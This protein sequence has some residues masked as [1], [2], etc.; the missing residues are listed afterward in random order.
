MKIHAALD[1]LMPPPSVIEPVGGSMLP[2]RRLK[3]DTRIGD[4]ATE[5]DFRRLCGLALG[6]WL[7]GGSKATTLEARLDSGW[8]PPGKRLPPPLAHEAYVLEIGTRLRLTASAYAGLAMGLQTLKQI[9]ESGSDAGSLPRCRIVDWPRL[10]MRGMHVDMARE[11]EYRPAHLKR[12]VE[13]AAYFRMNTLHLYLENKFV[14]SSA[15]EVAPP[16]V[17]TPAQAR[18]L[19]EYA[20]LFGVTVLPQIPTLGHMEHLLNGKYA[21]LRE[22]PASSFNLCPSHPKSR[23][24]LAGLIADAAAAFRSPFIH[25]GYDESESGVCPRCRER[26]T[27]HELLAEHL[28][29]LNSEVKKHGARTMIYGDKFL[30]PHDSPRSDACNGGSPA[31]AREALD[32]VSRDI[33]ITNWHYTA[34]YSG[35]TRLLVRAG[36]ETHIVTATNIYWHDAIPFHR[37]PHWIVPTIDNA[38]AEGATG[39]FNSNWEYYRGQFLDN[40]WFFQALAAERMWSDKP[41]IYTGWSSRFSRRFWGLERDY[42]AELAGL[43]ETMPTDRRKLF[44]DSSVLSEPEYQ[45][46]RPGAQTLREYAEAGQY[47]VEL[48]GEF[49]RRA[50]RNA[51]TLRM[52][53]MPGQIIRYLGVR[54]LAGL[55]LKS[56]MAAGDRS[57]ALACLRQIR[58]TA[59]RVRGRLEYGYRIYGGAVED[60]R[61]L[62]QH[63]AAIAACERTIRRASPR[64]LKATGISGLP[65]GGPL[66]VSQYAASR[67]LPAPRNIS[68][69]AP[70]PAGTRFSAIPTLRDLPGW[71]TGDVRGVHAGKNGMLYVRGRISLNRGGRGTL[72]YSADGPVKVWVNGRE[73]G[74]EPQASNPGKPDKFSAPAIWRRGLNTILFALHTNRG[75]AWGVMARCRLG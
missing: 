6:A 20:R 36:F 5:S 72:L 31:E 10:A 57:A 33:I 23:P 41:H 75:N 14:Y 49:R 43:A 9:L 3:L 26:G 44:L 60:R 29:W 35:T 45:L 62:A 74:C 13:N 70:P 15:P 52:I 18:E 53:D 38:V 59:D 73:V 17:M 25:V 54:S 27:P 55:M 42:Y 40:F 66:I 8:T 68:Q 16:R 46:G 21:A 34:P 22:T 30:S 19:C 4:A 47:L 39:A 2:P 28:N 7:A 64:R 24:F 32:K 67:L 56:A 69:A 63:L 51:D 11:M 12:V 61:R 48:A 71:E 58:E 1:D 50:R 37:G 65:T